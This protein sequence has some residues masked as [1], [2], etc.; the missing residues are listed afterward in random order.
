VDIYYCV[1]MNTKLNI[2]CCLSYYE[3]GLLMNSS[4]SIMKDLSFYYIECNCDECI[5]KDLLLYFYWMYYDEWLYEYYERPPVVL[6]WMKLSSMVIWVLQKIYLCIIL[7]VNYHEWWCEYYEGSIVVLYWTLIVMNGWMSNMK[8]I[9]VL[10]WMLYCYGMF[11]YALQRI[12]N[13]V[14]EW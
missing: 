3:F 10:Y 6:Y 4:M 7:M 14:T 12:Y 8:G 9:V 2:R 11:V 1:V 13:C 5:T